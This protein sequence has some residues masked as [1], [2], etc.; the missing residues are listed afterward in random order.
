MRHPGLALRR[1]FR[2]VAKHPEIL[3]EPVH[4]QRS[5]LVGDRQGMAPSAA[6]GISPGERPPRDPEAVLDDSKVLVQFFES[7]DI[8]HQEHMRLVAHRFPLQLHSR[9]S[10]NQRVPKEGREGARLAVSDHRWPL[11]R[12]RPVARRKH[13]PEIARKGL[14]PLLGLRFGIRIKRHRTGYRMAYECEGEVPLPSLDRKVFPDRRS[15]TVLTKL[16][17]LGSLPRSGRYALPPA[18]EVRFEDDVAPTNDG[19][20]GC[21]YG[22]AAGLVYVNEYKL[23]IVRDDHR[24]AHARWRPPPPSRRSS[25]RS[26]AQPARRKVTKGD[27]TCRSPSRAYPL[28]LRSYSLRRRSWRDVHLARH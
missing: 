12:V 10:E 28:R 11:E 24:P 19:G 2:V 14:L 7:T 26:R 15:R 9:C 4:Q 3:A 5:V 17:L 22:V 23:S 21:G 25:M 27:P 6:R 20:E 8:I 13:V 1:R 16:I 18:L